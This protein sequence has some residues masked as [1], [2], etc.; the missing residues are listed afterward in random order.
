MVADAWDTITFGDKFESSLADG[1]VGD[2]LEVCSRITEWLEDAVGRLPYA[3]GGGPFPPGYTYVLRGAGLENPGIT[4]GR[5]WVLKSKNN[6]PAPLNAM[7]F[8]EPGQIPGVEGCPAVMAAAAD[9]LGIEDEEI[10]VTVADAMAAA[11]DIQPC[12]TCARLVNAAAILRDEDGSRMAA[13][14][15]VINT[16]APAD[17]PFTPEVGTLIAA[18]FEGHAGDGTAYATALEYVDAF[19]EYVRV[20]D[21]EMGSPVGDSVEFVMEKHGAGIN[22]SPND[23][24]AAYVASRLEAIGG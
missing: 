12:D 1:R 23:N 4:D 21:T 14:A 17:V 10:E 15:E 16:V 24:V 20:L 22:A 6:P 19:A 5:A 3:L 2:R 9:E 11:G 18:A 7:Q 8:E 13:L